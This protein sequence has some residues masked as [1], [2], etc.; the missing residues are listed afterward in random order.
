[1]QAP[2]CRVLRS[3]AWRH[4][5]S[6]CAQFISS[7]WPNFASCTSHSYS[8]SGV[9]SWFVPKPGQ[10]PQ[11][12]HSLTHLALTALIF[13]Q[14]VATVLF[15]GGGDDVS[16]CIQLQLQ[17]ILTGEGNTLNWENDTP[18]HPGLFRATYLTYLSLL[19]LNLC[20]WS[21][22]N[23]QVMKFLSCGEAMRMRSQMFKVLALKRGRENPCF[24]VFL[25]ALHN[26]LL[27]LLFSV[28]WGV[29]VGLC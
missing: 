12:K 2:T 5:N 26:Y 28:G 8:L 14:S 25:S 21:E 24:P 10:D 19:S 29:F 3:F 11:A 7:N 22:R 16:S 18:L 23:V 17:L 6:I 1:M 20:C 4:C 9:S 13:L 27:L 15:Y